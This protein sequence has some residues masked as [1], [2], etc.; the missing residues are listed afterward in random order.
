MQSLRQRIKEEQDQQKSYV[1]VRRVDHS[2]NVVIKY[3]CGRN[4][5]RVPSSL[6]KGINCLLRYCGKERLMA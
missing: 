6:E 3:F 5:I 1:D 2:Y 4:H